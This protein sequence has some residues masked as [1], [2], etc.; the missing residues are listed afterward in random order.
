MVCLSEEQK[1]TLQNLQPLS[2]LV[3]AS[4]V[5]LATKLTIKWNSLNSVNSLSSAGQTIPFVIGIRPLV[6]VFYVY[7]EPILKR[8][9][10]R[11]ESAES[12]S[13][14]KLEPGPLPFEVMPIPYSAP[15]DLDNL[16]SERTTG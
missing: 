13:A 1:K 8:H 11:G 16:E 14:P 6:R 15:V 3:V 9:F 4:V 5:V 2:N 12:S 7:S 10:G